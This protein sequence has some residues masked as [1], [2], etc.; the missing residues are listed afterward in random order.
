VP[1]EVSDLFESVLSLLDKI[2]RKLHYFNLIDFT[3]LGPGTCDTIKAQINRFITSG[4]L[5]VNKYFS[6]SWSCRILQTVRCTE[7]Y[8][9]ETYPGFSRT[10]ECREET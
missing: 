4:W 9:F 2:Q 1:E 5:N 6:I 3:N 7:L 8:S 10:I